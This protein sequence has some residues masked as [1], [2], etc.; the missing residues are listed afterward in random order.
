[1]GTPAS[2]APSHDDGVSD[3][4]GALVGDRYEVHS[5][6]GEGPV[7]LV[8]RARERASG[9]EV[10]V[11]LL[12]IDPDEAIAAY[13]GARQLER[14]AEAVGHPRAVVPHVAD[15]IGSTVFCTTPFL[16][17]GSVETLLAARAPLPFDRIVA[18]L[19][20]AAEVLDRA[21]ERRILH[22]GLKPS[23]LLLDAEGRVHVTDFG[24]ASI[25]GR[26][27]AARAP[28][29]DAYVAP[30]QWRGQRVSGQADQYALGIIAYE[31]I[32]G[33]RR[34]DAHNVEG[35][36]VL[37]PLEVNSFG[38]LRPDLG[39]HVN[40]AL[41]R[42][43]SAGTANRFATASEFVAALA[44]RSGAAAGEDGPRKQGFFRRELVV[45]V[46]VALLVAAL[47][48]VLLLNEGVQR[49][50][51][52]A[53]RAA[54]VEV[55]EADL[56]GVSLPDVSGLLPRSIPSPRLKLPSLGGGA[57]ASAAPPSTGG[58]TGGRVDG[59]YFSSTGTRGAGGGTGGGGVPASTANRGTTAGSGA[60]TVGAGTAV[61]A[62]RGTA[63]GSFATTGA[64]TSVAANRGGGVAGTM[65]TA[66]GGVVAGT[67]APAPSGLLARTAQWFTR[68][69]GG[70]GTPLP[71][72]A[73]RPAGAVAEAR[74]TGVAEGAALTPRAAGAAPAARAAPALRKA[75][76]YLRVSAVGGAPVVLVDGLP[77]GT[78]PLLV[79]V[80]PGRHRVEVRSI[81]SRYMPGTRQ[82]G[83]GD[84]DTLTLEFLRVPVPR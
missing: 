59:P 25:F 47:F 57:V 72:G 34:A 19:A 68:V 81:G 73:P 5:V 22:G 84:R 78:A 63:T 39:M 10:A 18:I 69:R 79:R 49:S 64:G 3:R 76:A 31:L 46:G 11:K 23:N 42:A 35:I 52:S 70:T 32:T 9:R 40:S 66:A 13:E 17:G 21:H 16:P 50:L 1:M 37:E 77:R 56:P 53:A 12:A 6:L 4:L 74:A 14:V 7:G 30:E 75:A 71:D 8:F 62:N 80:A 51:T 82:V 27:G 15:P 54:E 48:A 58:T 61:A 60:G 41:A 55:S 44:G 2:Y 65:T 24:V 29:A 33:R 43:M 26:S 20:D 83:V 28:G 45:A 67:P 38:P 36:A